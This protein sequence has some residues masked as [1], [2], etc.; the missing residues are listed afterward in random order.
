MDFGKLFIYVLKC[1]LTIALILGVIFYIAGL[2]GLY[3]TFN[4]TIFSFYI[5]SA[6]IAN[7]LFIDNLKEKI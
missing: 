3:E 2:I 6:F 7:Y 1:E 4:L 5:L